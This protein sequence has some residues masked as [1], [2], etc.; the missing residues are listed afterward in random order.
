MRVRWVEYQGWYEAETAYEILEQMKERDWHIP[1]TV[2]DFKL[3]VARR[4]QVLGVILV[5]WDATSF[6]LALENAGKIEIK[7][8]FEKNSKFDVRKNRDT[9]SLKK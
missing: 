5:F 8:D 2:Y 4:C 7:W 1:K 9:E 6:L 3:N